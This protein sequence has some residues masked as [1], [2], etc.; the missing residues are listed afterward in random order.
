MGADFMAGAV[1]AAR[2][3]PARLEE[4]NKL[5]DSLNNDD[6]EEIK[7]SGCIDVYENDEDAYTVCREKIKEAAEWLSGM[8][9][10]DSKTGDL[11]GTDSREC[12][13]MYFNCLPYV[14]TGGMSWGDPATEALN[15]LDPLLRCNKVCN[16]LVEYA[17]EDHETLETKRTN[18]HRFFFSIELPVGILDRSSLQ[19]KINN[20]LI[21]EDTNDALLSLFSFAKFTLLS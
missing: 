14:V 13:I 17:R 8:C 5:I 1:P 16:R 10:Y 2:V 18:T 19:N 20:I 6:L 11:A 15:E 4:L 12:G 3:T 9:L 21:A 7:E